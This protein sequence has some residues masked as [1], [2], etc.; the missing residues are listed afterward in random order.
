MTRRAVA[1]NHHFAL[2]AQPGHYDDG[3]DDEG[4]DDEGDDDEGDDDGDDYDD[5]D[6][7]G[8]DDD[9]SILVNHPFALKA[10]PGQIFKFKL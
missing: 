10:P 2:A 7:D 4:D 3:V 1:A 8:H 9:D 5:D 6:Y